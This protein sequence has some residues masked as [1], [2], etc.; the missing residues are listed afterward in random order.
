METNRNKKRRRADRW[1]PSISAST[2]SNYSEV[3]HKNESVTEE[4]ALAALLASAQ[5]RTEEQKS[6]SLARGDTTNFRFDPDKRKAKTN[7]RKP[8]PKT[9]RNQQSNRWGSANDHDDEKESN[10]T[11]ATQK[12][13]LADF[14]LSG[15]LATDSRTGNTYNGV[16]LKFSEPPEARTPNTRWRFYVF[17]D[18]KNIETL[19]VSKQSAYLFGREK[20]IADIFV[21][22]PSLS[23]QHCVLQFRAIP[24]KDDVTVVR[25]KPYLM[26]LGTANGT[27]INGTR[28]E[29]AKY[30]ELKK[31]D[32]ITLGTSTREYV[33]LTENTT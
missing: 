16:L 5:K 14:G 25:C 6:S 22:H 17:R 12:K 1:G 29:D 13:E 23:R 30:Y 33:L 3:P 15:A 9:S 19:H 20:K 7:N 31:K 28:L 24:E 8:S 21:E 32:T 11:A 4:E 18:G 27:F 2:S 10:A 26:D